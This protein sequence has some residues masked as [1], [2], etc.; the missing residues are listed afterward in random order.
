M[1]V[2]GL[3]DAEAH[4]DRQLGLLAQPSD[5]LEQLVRQLVALAGDTGD[6]DAI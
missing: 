4:A 6:A 1:D 3:A 5:L 2:R